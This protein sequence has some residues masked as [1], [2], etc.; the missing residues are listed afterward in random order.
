MRTLR[1]RRDRGAVLII[2]VGI[3]AVLCLVAISFARLMVVER[4]VSKNHRE[5]VQA[6]MAA[7]SGI[8]HA[9]AWFRDEKNFRPAYCHEVDDPNSP[10]IFRDDVGK[11]VG[12]GMVDLL[13]AK[14]PSFCY[15][16]PETYSGV[17]PDPS[18]T[19]ARNFYKLR[20]F[21]TASQVNLNNPDR[22]LTKL[23]E[24]LGDA[25]QKL[26]MVDRPKWWRPTFGAVPNPLPPAV[27]ARILAVRNTL[28]NGEFTS[29]EQIRTDANGNE[30]LS[31]RLYRLVAD[32]LAVRGWKNDRAVVKDG[33]P[34]VQVGNPGVQTS[35]WFRAAAQWWRKGTTVNTLLPV[36]EPRY[37]ININTAAKPVLIA[38]LIGFSAYRRRL[39][40]G[41]TGS[42][43]A[44]SALPANFTALLV[45]NGDGIADQVPAL[46]YATAERL[47]QAIVDFRSNKTK[48]GPF[49]N[50]Q[51]FFLFIR[52]Q[53]YLGATPQQ[54]AD[55]QEMII[56]NCSPNM[57]SHHFNPEPQRYSSVTKE[58][59]FGATTEFCFGPMG[60]FE[61]TSLGWVQD[62][63]QR[64]LAEV[65]LS[66]EV[67]V[68]HVM[69]RESQ[70]DWITSMRTAWNATTGPEPM[71]NVVDS[72]AKNAADSRLVPLYGNDLVARGGNAYEGWVQPLTEFVQLTG[73]GPSNPPLVTFRGPQ[74]PGQAFYAP[75]VYQRAPALPFDAQRAPQTA[76]STSAGG[77]G[78]LLGKRSGETIFRGESL[79]P[80]GVLFANYNDEELSYAIDGNFSPL[81]GTISFWVK[82]T[83]GYDPKTN[84]GTGYGAHEPLF[85][86]SQ[87][88]T[89]P[90]TTPAW[91][92]TWKLER[93]GYVIRST[94]FIWCNPVPQTYPQ[95]L[96]AQ[97][98][99]VKYLWTEKTFNIS[100]PTTMWR[101]NE[102][103]HIVHSWNGYTEQT[104]WTDANHPAPRFVEAGAGIGDMQI[105]PPANPPNAK[106]VELASIDP[107]MKCF[108]GGFIFNRTSTGTIH[109][110]FTDQGTAITR[111]GNCK[112]DEIRGFNV[113]V[114]ST[115]NPVQ[116][117]L[118]PSRFVTSLGSFFDGEFSSEA[119]GRIAQVTFTTLYPTAFGRTEFI[120]NAAAARYQPNRGLWPTTYTLSAGSGS[121]T[122]SDTGDRTQAQLYTVKKN[123]R[124]RYRITF[125]STGYDNS[126]PVV[127]D[128]TIY[129][130]VP[131]VYFGVRQVF[132]R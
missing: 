63:T 68:C 23:L 82:L 93:Y 105:T 41:Q 19:Y 70:R 42:P 75:Y 118:L 8:E 35:N 131:P 103:H 12:A 90:G 69:Y 107:Q 71:K 26:G 80:D 22:L 36:L 110:G 113:F 91:G 3:L 6:R 97:I 92:V 101:D 37:P 58:L 7:E 128:V 62:N 120:Q 130:L 77:E 60:Y 52:D 10:W 61:I 64:I 33:A 132:D 98:Q 46:D 89:P 20:V 95:Q 13:D 122:G 54:A 50:W 116:L 59:L 4:D 2:T 78:T 48:G 49:R 106:L 85:Y 1:R 30:I 67:K 76:G 104:L 44:G 112:I 66:T 79:A 96:P 127:D 34:N 123:T 88:I 124:I 86:T 121:F 73:S 114:P 24:N 47:A 111:I 94:R 56:A 108:P 27:V 84:R 29:K 83:A 115:S 74:L 21:D 45:D 40:A 11:N 32:Y 99:P 17:V 81:Q 5:Y 126:C 72:T 28:P 16:P 102:W 53:A 125:R 119:D 100:S 117:G 87:L 39:R 25:I 51:Q 57:M 129:V 109:R 31:P 65:E 18:F 38:N 55:R 15:G 14:S 9:V 43:Q